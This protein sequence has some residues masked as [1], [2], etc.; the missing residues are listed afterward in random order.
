MKMYFKRFVDV[1]N[2]ET[3]EIKKST[4]KCETKDAETCSITL[5]IRIFYKYEKTLDELGSKLVTKVAEHNDK[6]T[7]FIGIVVSKK[8]PSVAYA[9]VS[10]PNGAIECDDSDL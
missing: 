1:L 3:D 7:D 9:T 4:V 8:N 5:P 6:L 10:I 2:E